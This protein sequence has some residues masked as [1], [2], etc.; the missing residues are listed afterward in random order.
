MASPLSLIPTLQQ[1]DML[2]SIFSYLKLS[3][4]SC[5]SRTSKLWNSCLPDIINTAWISHITQSRLLSWDEDLG[6]WYNKKLN[7]KAPANRGRL[8][9][10]YVYRPFLHE[11]GAERST[12]LILQVRQQLTSL[13]LIRASTFDTK[14]QIKEFELLF[15]IKGEPNFPELKILTLQV[16]GPE[17]RLNV[18]IPPPEP[19]LPSITLES[20]L[21]HCPRL[22]SFTIR[23]A[24]K[25]ELLSLLKAS[26]EK[27]CELED[28]QI[29]VCRDDKFTDYPPELNVGFN[30]LNS[31]SI[32]CDEATEEW[33]ISLARTITTTKLVDLELYFP[34][35]PLSEIGIAYLSRFSSLRELTLRLN[36]KTIINLTREG[37]FQFVNLTNLQKLEIYG[38][39][40]D[41]KVMEDFATTNHFSFSY[42]W[43]EKQSYKLERIPVNHIDLSDIV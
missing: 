22:T 39:H 24:E 29:E 34:H 2:K 40:L 8:D 38:C 21:R 7:L 36:P 26:E 4:L 41:R 9:K 35:E 15:P 42:T 16:P 20:V 23:E 27:D 6:Y 43:L 32:F 3:E 12:C 37:I 11:I 1:P 28:V 25:M 10:M 33:I 30:K 14:G 17:R 18:L 5:C 19:S 31:L 13:N